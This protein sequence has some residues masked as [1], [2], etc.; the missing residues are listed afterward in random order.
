MDYI[1]ILVED[2]DDR[3]TETPGIVEALHQL[4]RLLLLLRTCRFAWVVVGVYVLK[5][6]VNESAYRAVAFN[7]FCKAQAPRAPVAAHLAAD[8]LPIALGFAD[9]CVDLLY[10]VNALV[11]NLL[12]RSLSIS[13]QRQEQCHHRKYQSPVVHIVLVFMLFRV[14][15]VGMP[16]VPHRR[17]GR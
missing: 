12:C 17:A 6:L 8:V 15:F 4:L 10:R 14:M 11:V 13:V 5:V 1:A 9:S 2:D 3:K 7:E 16:V